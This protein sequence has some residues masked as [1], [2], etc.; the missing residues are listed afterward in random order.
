L[1]SVPLDDVNTIQL[2]KST[3]DLVFSCHSFHHFVELE[4][5]MDQVHQSLTPHGL[6][7]LDEYVGPTQFQWTTEKQ[8]GLVNSLLALLPDRLRAFPWTARKDTEPCMLP[9][10]IIAISPF[11]LIE[12]GLLP[13]DFMILIRKPKDA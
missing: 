5:V 11:G 7:V 1:S 2:P 9:E 4:Y 10:Q 8:L 12:A 6:F 3:Y 13:S